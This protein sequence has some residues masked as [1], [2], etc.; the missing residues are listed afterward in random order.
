M[1]DVIY[2][3]CLHYIGFTQKKLHQIFEKSENYR[4]VFDKISAHNLS[5][6]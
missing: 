5:K 3:V 6:Y 1:E 2:L 4:E